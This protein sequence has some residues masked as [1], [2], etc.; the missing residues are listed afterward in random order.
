MYQPA[1]NDKI[2]LGL[3]RPISVGYGESGDG[4]EFSV[5]INPFGTKRNFYT[6]KSLFGAYP[7]SYP[8]KDSRIRLAAYRS[9]GG[10]IEDFI[11]LDNCRII[12]GNGL[13]L[14]KNMKVHESYHGFPRGLE[15]ALKTPYSLR[16]T[17]LDIRRKNNLK[18][19]LGSFH[20][21]NPSPK[22]VSQRDYLYFADDESDFRLIA[23]SLFAGIDRSIIARALAAYKAR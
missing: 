20:D 19:T 6:H 3:A 8:D 5:C 22:R 21:V 14:P 2:A 23:Y 7:L 17:A 1:Y 13:A 4:K 10:T 11:E 15:L 9:F 16:K 18:P 12:H